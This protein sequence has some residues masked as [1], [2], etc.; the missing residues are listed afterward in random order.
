MPKLMGM[1]FGSIE[2]TCGGC[3]LTGRHHY[4]PLSRILCTQ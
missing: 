1:A 4:A 3:V 2:F